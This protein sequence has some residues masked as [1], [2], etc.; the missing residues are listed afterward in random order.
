MSDVQANAVD[1][2]FL[3][4]GGV[5]YEKGEAR[6]KVAKKVEESAETAA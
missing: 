1:F 5:F 3:L 6:E 4:D 2:V